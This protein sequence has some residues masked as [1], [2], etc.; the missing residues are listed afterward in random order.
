MTMICNLS[1]AVINVF[2][3]AL[4]IMVFGWG[5]AGA[6]IATVIGQIFSG[7]LALTYLS[8]CKTVSVT[9]KHL[10]PNAPYLKRIISLGAASSF[11]QVAMM[12]VQ[13]ALNNS[14]KYYGAKSEYGEAI[15]IAS[16]GI[17]T[18]VNQLFFSVIIGI[19]QG[20]QPIESYNYGAKNYERV[21]KAYILAILA[22]GVLS[23]FSFLSF[24]LFPRQ[25]I[26]LFGKGD[27][28]YYKFGI[29]Y[30]R[31]FL[32]FT[33]VNFMQPIT[34]TFFTSIGKAYKGIFLSLTRQIIFLLPL[35]LILPLFI[36]IDGILYS[37]LLADLL[38]FI[39]TLIMIVI[40]FRN[41]SNLQKDTTN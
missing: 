4:F 2:L 27:E 20:T 30:F 37:G 8:H 22:G 36:G 21:K 26:S 1:G 10:I 31:I 13:I 16:A 17:V 32:F 34:S 7:I 23:V 9:R 12:I 3:D 29:N 35:I 40:E 25:I 24:Q 14:L 18:K 5:M 28:I 19:A 11:N 39:V 41:I 15:P 6:A 33:I 38:A